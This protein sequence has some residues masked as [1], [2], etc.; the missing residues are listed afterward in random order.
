MNISTSCDKSRKAVANTGEECVLLVR[1]LA[2]NQG[3]YSKATVSN[4]LRTG[5]KLLK[6]TIVKVTNTQNNKKTKV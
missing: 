5:Q 2:K 4:A 1:G 3:D 6:N